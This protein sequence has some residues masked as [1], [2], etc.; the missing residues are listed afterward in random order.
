MKQEWLFIVFVLLLC[1]PAN[2]SVP[3]TTKQCVR[4]ETCETNVDIEAGNVDCPYIKVRLLSDYKTSRN[5]T[6]ISELKSYMCNREKR[7]FCCPPVSSLPMT[8]KQCARG[9]TCES[10][11]DIEEG[12]V[13]CPYIQ[14]RLLSD[15][16]T[17]RNQTIITE[18]KSA[19]CNRESKGFCC[20]A[21]SVSVV[22]SV[23]VDVDISPRE[24]FTCEAPRVPSSASSVSKTRV[25]RCGGANTLVPQIFG[26]QEAKGQFPFMVA[27]VTRDSLNPFC[28]GVLVTRECIT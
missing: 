6:I 16:K 19:T 1:N 5:Q 14:T 12:N 7:G 18:L 23:S 22:P 26:G 20:P 13:V 10:K 8:T 2:S 17:S 9:E 3:M 25:E 11:V 21:P 28:G 24:R 15:Y 27:F 4:G